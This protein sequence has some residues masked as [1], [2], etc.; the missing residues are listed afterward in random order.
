MYFYIHKH[1]CL[2]IHTYVYIYI[3]VLSLGS[4]YPKSGVEG[5]D[6]PEMRSFGWQ[7]L[8]REV[9]VLSAL[10]RLLPASVSQLRL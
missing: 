8:V 3:D 7:C 10:T 5:F 2:H 6:G 9:S 1:I 4:Q